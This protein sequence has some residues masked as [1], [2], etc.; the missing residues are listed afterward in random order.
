MALELYD[1]MGNDMSIEAYRV[2]GQIQVM[3]ENEDGEEL[4]NETS[5]PFAWDSLVYFA[6]QVLD[7]NKRLEQGA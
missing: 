1:I 6:Q 2:G 7:V 5:H 4:Y 3:V